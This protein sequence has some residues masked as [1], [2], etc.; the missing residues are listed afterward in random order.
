MA[1][2]RKPTLRE[3][4]WGRP[5]EVFGCFRPWPGP[6]IPPM[7]IKSG[8]IRDLLKILQNRLW[9]L[10]LIPIRSACVHCAHAGI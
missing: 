10:L 5:R 7:P 4:E 2:G 8:E 6:I 1:H 9:D 3:L